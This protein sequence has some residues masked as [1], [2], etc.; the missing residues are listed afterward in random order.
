MAN[1][2]IPEKA[3]ESNSHYLICWSSDWSLDWRP[4]PTKDEAT[5]LAGRMQGRNES[6]IIVERDDECERCMVFQ[7][8]P[9]RAKEAVD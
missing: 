7:S 1:P 8:K 9:F 5:E 3:P 2:S 6:Y 4:F